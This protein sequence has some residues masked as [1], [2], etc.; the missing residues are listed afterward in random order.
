M[1]QYESFFSYPNAIALDIDC[2]HLVISPNLDE[3]EEPMPPFPNEIE[4]L[5]KLHIIKNRKMTNYNYV[6]P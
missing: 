3:D 6:Y 2:S 1:E 5:K 4:L